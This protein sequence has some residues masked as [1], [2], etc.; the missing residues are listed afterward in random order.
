MKIN[1]FLVCLSLSFIVACERKTDSEPKVSA[2]PVEV[3][4][5]TSEP[6]PVS[7]TSETPKKAQKADIKVQ[8]SVK[9]SAVSVGQSMKKTTPQVPQEA[10]VSTEQALGDTVDHAREV[11]KSQDSGS[12]QRADKAESEMADMLK[13]K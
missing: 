13:S 3:I 11:T 6:L 9:A 1:L 10:K 7:A 12:R 2:T 4:Q 5:K 8:E